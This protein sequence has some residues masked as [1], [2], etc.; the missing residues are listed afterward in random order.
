M[1]EACPVCLSTDSKLQGDYRGTHP[2][3]LGMKRVRCLTCELIFATPMP[4]ESA[5][6]QFNASYFMTAHGG[7]PNSPVSSGFFT[8]IARLRG[9]HLDRYLVN[10]ATTVSR[11]LQLGPGPGFFARNWLEHHPST[12]YTAIETDSSCHASLAKLGVRLVEDVAA[13]GAR[14]SV[15]LVVMSHVLEHVSN[16]VQFLSDS[17]RNLRKGGALF[18]EVPCRDCEHKSMD[19]PHLLF[20]DKAPMQ[21]LLVNLDFEDI[22]VSYHGQEIAK[23]RTPSRFNAKMMA[24]RSRLISLGVVAPFGHMRQGMECIASQLERA[25]VAPFLAHRESSTPAWWLRASAKKR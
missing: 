8:A 4:S 15:D 19:E 18:I 5:L 17:T 24:L 6:Q 7:Q 14:E 20:F 11:V 1:N 9:A 21:H 10:H 3:F 25:I 12:I 13:H 22:E 16:P 2:A 23:L